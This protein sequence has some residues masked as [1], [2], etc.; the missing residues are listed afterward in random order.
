MIGHLLHVEM[1]EHGERI[2][3]NEALVQELVV[4]VVVVINV[5][6]F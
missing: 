2:R 6:L 4:S 1:I 5:G 3:E